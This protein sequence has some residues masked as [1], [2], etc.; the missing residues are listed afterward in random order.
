MFNLYSITRSHNAIRQLFR[1]ARDSAS[2]LPPLFAVIPCSK[3][4]IMLGTHKREAAFRRP[5]A[6]RSGKINQTTRLNSSRTA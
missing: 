2:N 3:L 1:I 6:K 4:S 5:L